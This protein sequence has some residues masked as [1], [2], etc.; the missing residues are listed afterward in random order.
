MSIVESNDGGDTWNDPLQ[1]DD[2]DSA[3]FIYRGVSAIYSGGGIYVVWT[4]DR[5]DNADIYFDKIP[6]FSD[7]IFVMVPLLILTIIIKKRKYSRQ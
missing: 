6:E 4:D 2:E 7:F 5:N 1:V 3:E